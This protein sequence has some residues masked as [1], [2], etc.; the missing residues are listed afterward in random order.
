MY[1][2]NLILSLKIFCPKSNTCQFRM[3]K[4]VDMSVV[5]EAEYPE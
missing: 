1:D 2:L 4:I 3:T 5:L